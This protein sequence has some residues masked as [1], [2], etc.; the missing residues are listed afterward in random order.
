MTAFTSFRRG[1]AAL[2]LATAV[3]AA[4]AA[5]PAQKIAGDDI[6]ATVDGV[7]ITERDLAVAGLEFRDQ[8]AQM[9]GDPRSNLIHLLINIRLGAKAAKGAGMNEDPTVASRMT[10]AEDQVLYGEFLRKKFEAAVTEE[11]VRER[12]DTEMA[13]FVPEDQVHVRHILVASEG[14]AKA[15]IVELD[16]GAD[17]ATLAAEKSIDGSAANGGDL[18]FIWPGRTVEPFE[19]A[20]YALAVGEYTKEPV[21]T[22]FGWHVIKAEEKREQ[23]RPTFEGEARRIQQEILAETFDAAVQALRAEATIEIVPV[24]EP[25]PAEPETEAEPANDQ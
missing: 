2:V 15:I 19:K 6:V 16:G 1:G 9:P 11:A 8:L 24:A 12:F 3:F 20:A 22:N 17:F 21:Q 7:D 4:P 10:L 5:A 13:D 18:D 23:P 14:E 25:E